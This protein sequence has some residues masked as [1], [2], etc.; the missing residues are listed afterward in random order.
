[1]ILEQKVID[2]LRKEMPKLKRVIEW[3]GMYNHIATKIVKSIKKTLI[4]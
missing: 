2:I 1:M 3:D 4:E